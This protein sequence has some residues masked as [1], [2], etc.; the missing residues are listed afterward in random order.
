MSWGVCFYLMDIVED[1]A[2]DADDEGLKITPGAVPR[3]AGDINGDAFVEF[4][5]GII[6]RHPAP[7]AEDVVKFIRAFMV[8]HLRIRD[9]QMVH[10]PGGLVAFFN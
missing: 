8:M 3:A 10:L 4:D 2:G 5:L 7:A 1:A 6:Q 9:L